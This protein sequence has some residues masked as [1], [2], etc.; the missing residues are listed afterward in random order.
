VRAWRRL[1]SVWWVWLPVVAGAAWAV[2]ARSA[3]A[4]SDV[5]A[6]GRFEALLAGEPDVLRRLWPTLVALGSAAGP[7]VA[8]SIVVSL[9]GVLFLRA[10]RHRAGI[11]SAVWLWVLITAYTAVVTVTYLVSPYDIAWHLG[12]SADRV[13]T[14]IIL[15]ALAS[16]A[17]WAVVAVSTD[18]RVEPP[19]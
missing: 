14:L 18:E 1:G 8:G 5:V 3:G 17:C 10:A 4:R 7:Y 11:G 12:T 9:L 19:R 13:S 6:G 16:A 15:L 2:I